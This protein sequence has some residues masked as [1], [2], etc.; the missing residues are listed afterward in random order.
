M[1]VSG[2]GSDRARQ[3]AQKL[4]EENVD[5]LISFGSAGALSP[6]LASGDLMHPKEALSDGKRYDTTSRLSEAIMRRLSQKNIIINTGPLVTVAGV[7]AKTS[8]KHELFQQTGAV[9]VDMETAGILDVARSCQVPAFALRAIVDTADMMIP[10]V[11][12]QRTDQFGQVN[13]P[14]L[15]VDLLR[16]PGQIPAVLRLGKAWRQAGKTMKL[17]GHE[18]IQTLLCR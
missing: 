8:D 1:I 14:A 13:T 15:I 2:M 9:S 12:M 3:A 5:C 7:L 18:L 17:A 10:E 16:Q 6:E 4:V 11:A